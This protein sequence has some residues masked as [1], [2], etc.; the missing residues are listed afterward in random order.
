MAADCGGALDHR[1]PHQIN[2]I[3]VGDLGDLEIVLFAYDDG[4]VVAYYTHAIVRC[5]KVHGDQ[6]RGPCASPIRQVAHPKPFFH[7]NVGK[8][9]WGLAIHGQ[10]RLIAVSSNLH[11]VTVFAFALSHANVPVRF[12]EVDDSPGLG[13][14]Q[15]AFALQRHFLSRTR[16]WRVILP[17]GRAANN[18]PNISF[19]DD[20]T[21]EAE[22]VVA[23][24]IVGNAW[25]L[26]IWKI[27][28]LPIRWPD[29]NARDQQMMHGYAIFTLKRRM[30][31]ELTALQYEGLGRVGASIQQLQARQDDPRITRCAWRRGPCCH[32]SGGKQSLVGH[33][34]QS[35]LHQGVFVQSRKPIPATPYPRRLCEDACNQAR[36]SRGRPLGRLGERE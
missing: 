16:T 27:G 36:V 22:K 34:V 2:H 25:L 6:T 12:P 1:F 32:E 31:T 13:C 20:E 10:S 24:D 26:D 30:D 17:L 7:E 23:V 3:I 9:A 29:T 4:D 5:I 8:S 11:E 18:I 15:T 33:H 21:G 19:A 28:A 14:G 35:V